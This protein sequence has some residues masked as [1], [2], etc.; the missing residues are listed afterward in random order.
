VAPD[1]AELWTNR[2]VA[3]VQMN[4][5]EEALVDARAGVARA[6][7]N[8]ILRNILGEILAYLRR[9]PEAL[10]QFRAAAAIDPASPLYFT[11][12]ALPLGAMGRKEE[13]CRVLREAAARYGADRIPRDSASWTKALGCP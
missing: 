9:W 12:Q 13:A 7:G 6:P 11:N 3:L 8:P 10:E 2:A 4:R 5:N 1:A